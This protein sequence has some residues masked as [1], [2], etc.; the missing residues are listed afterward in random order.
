MGSDNYKILKAM[1]SPVIMNV[2]DE[3]QLTKLVQSLEH[4]CVSVIRLVEVPFI[5]E[6]QFLQV[7]QFSAKIRCELAESHPSGFVSPHTLYFK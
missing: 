2:S 3:N 1:L 5:D 4:A 7:R 6:N